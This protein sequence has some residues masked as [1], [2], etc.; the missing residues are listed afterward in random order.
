MDAPDR[1]QVI[2][3]VIET[4]RAH[5]ENSREHAASLAAQALNEGQLAE[6]QLWKHVQAALAVDLV[7]VARRS[8]EIGLGHG[9]RGHRFA[10]KLAQSALAE[11]EIEEYEFWKS[12]EE[13]LASRG[14]NLK[15]AG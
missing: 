5:G 3:R 10:A 7:E 1:H 6:H 14:H 13:D 4:R 12:V 15:D 2:E 9:W 11:G 8:Q